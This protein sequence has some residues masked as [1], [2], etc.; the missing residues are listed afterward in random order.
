M[1]GVVLVQI[2]DVRQL[3]RGWGCRGDARERAAL[4]WSGPG[5][6]VLRR[7]RGVEIADTGGRWPGDGVG[8][9]VDREGRL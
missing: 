5:A 3:R 8:G 6:V 1:K 4:D 7:Q 9:C 2:W